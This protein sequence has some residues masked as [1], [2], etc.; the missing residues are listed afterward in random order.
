VILGA[1]LWVN[2]G[3]L[4]EAD[5]KGSMDHLGNL[6]AFLRFNMEDYFQLRIKAQW[7]T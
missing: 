1:F 5:N 4:L 6:G 2:Y 3:T 7:I